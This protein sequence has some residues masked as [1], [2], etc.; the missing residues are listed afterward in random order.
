VGRRPVSSDIH[1]GVFGRRRNWS[2]EGSVR[3]R[4]RWGLWP[5]QL[6]EGESETE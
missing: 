1:C 4:G 2:E 5:A 6:V 3:K